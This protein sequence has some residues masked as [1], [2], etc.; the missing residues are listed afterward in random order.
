MIPSPTS[1]KRAGFTLLELGIVLIVIGF[2]AAAILVGKELLFNTRVQQQM[3]QFEQYNTAVALFSTRYDN[4]PGDF[5]ASD[6]LRYR[7]TFNI[8]QFPLRSG[9]KGHGDGNGIFEPCSAG[10]P[11]I[12]YSKPGCE[13]LMFWSDLAAANLIQGNKANPANGRFLGTDE[14]LPGDITFAESKLYMPETRISPDATV[15]VST[16]PKDGSAWFVFIHYTPGSDPE[17]LESHALTPAQAYAF[18]SKLDDASPMTGNVLQNSIVSSHGFPAIT[19]FF[20]PPIQGE[21]KC[22]A[23]DHYNITTTYT[24]DLRCDFLNIRMSI[25]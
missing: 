8:A 14:D 12:D 10:T 7:G 19:H 15:M 18:D 25:N 23:D 17:D 5:K 9:E 22:V 24:D 1:Y 11:P 21:D 16:R 6:V 4:L 20:G 13:L 3:K 2:L